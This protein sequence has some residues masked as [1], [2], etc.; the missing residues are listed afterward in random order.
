MV[1]C[2]NEAD[3]GD[4]SQ[5][6]RSICLQLQQH[7]LSRGLWS[8]TFATKDCIRSQTLMQAGELWIGV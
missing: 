7:G 3:G 5:Y 6:F 2:R 8:F 4:C 1:S